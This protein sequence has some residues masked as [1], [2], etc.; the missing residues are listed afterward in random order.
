VRGKVKAQ[1]TEGEPFPEI[2]EREVGRVNEEKRYQL[3]AQF[4]K[5][6]MRFKDEHDEHVGASAEVLERQVNSTQD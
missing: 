2:S 4:L 5:A 1:Y 6:F 3:N